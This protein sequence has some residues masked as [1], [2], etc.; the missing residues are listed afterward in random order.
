MNEALATKR[1]LQMRNV[2]QAQNIRATLFLEFPCKLATHTATL[3]GVEC[4]S[5]VIVWKL[6]AK[7]MD[8]GLLKISANRK[9]AQTIL[10]SRARIQQ[11][12]EI[13][14]AHFFS[15]AAFR[16]CTNSRRIPSLACQDAMLTT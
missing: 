8:N 2:V 6:V 15:F 10:H 1:Y 7:A 5:R 4:L 13:F 9:L 12:A 14:A 3:D 11:C 16:R